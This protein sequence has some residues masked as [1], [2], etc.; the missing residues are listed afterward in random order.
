MKSGDYAMPTIEEDGVVFSAAAE[1]FVKA[2]LCYE[3]NQRPSAATSCEH[4][5]LRDDL[6]AA[7][8]PKAGGSSRKTTGSGGRKK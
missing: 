8:S 3:E 6:G 7:S 5:W 1:D 2:L 4:R